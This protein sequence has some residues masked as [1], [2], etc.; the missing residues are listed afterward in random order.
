ML[1]DQGKIYLCNK[2][3]VLYFLF[4][5]S[6]S[7]TIGPLR[8][9]TAFS[10]F[11]T[12][13]TY[14][15]IKYSKHHTFCFGSQQRGQ[16]WPS[17]MHLGFYRSRASSLTVP[18]ENDPHRYS[19]ACILTVITFCNCYVYVIVYVFIICLFH[20]IMQILRRWQDQAGCRGSCCNSST[21]GSGSGQ[22]T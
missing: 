20:N 14:L 7:P 13:G 11:S 1:N 2:L 6:Q 12:D 9:S 8:V 4:L 5:Y 17:K 10:F 19:V 16:L 15:A 3:T 22:I 21:L 18:C